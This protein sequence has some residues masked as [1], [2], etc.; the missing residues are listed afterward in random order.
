MR[1]EG[2]E[3]EEWRVRGHRQEKRAG[4][5]WRDMEGSYEHCLYT[6]TG[7]LRI[8][9]LRGSVLCVLMRYKYFICLLPWSKCHIIM[10]DARGDQ[11]DKCGKLINATELK[12]S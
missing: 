1:W 7:F 10:Q 11:C 5:A 12:V 9:L 4:N 3:R 8:D 6:N 2:K